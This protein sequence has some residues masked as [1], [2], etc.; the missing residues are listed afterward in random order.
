M[1]SSFFGGLG[2]ISVVSLGYLFPYTSLSDCHFLNRV[3]KQ[4]HFWHVTH[5][6]VKAYHIYSFQVP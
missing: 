4:T 6:Y 1:L 3:Q 2:G 5:E